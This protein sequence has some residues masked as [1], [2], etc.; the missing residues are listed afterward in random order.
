MRA[1][2]VDANAGN[3]VAGIGLQTPAAS[4]G[5]LDARVAFDDFRLNSGQL[6]CPS[7]W[8]DSAPDWQPLG[9]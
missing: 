6:S 5:H 9:K 8:D 7:W 2:P 1:R 3:G 4:F